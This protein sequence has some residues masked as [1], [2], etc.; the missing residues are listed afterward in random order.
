MFYGIPGYKP[1]QELKELK[2]VSSVIYLSNGAGFPNRSL[3]KYE[4][5]DWL[6]E[7][8]ED[9]GQDEDEDEDEQEEEYHSLPDFIEEGDENNLPLHELLGNSPSFFLN[10]T[11]TAYRHG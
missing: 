8:R 11:Y 1:I 5:A 3:K 7:E 4:L 2:V 6:Y 10:H 9:D